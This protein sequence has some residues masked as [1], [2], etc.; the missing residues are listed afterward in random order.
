MTLTEQELQSAVWLKLNEY[1]SSRV[2]ADRA[3]ND[4][5][6]DAIATARLRGR[7]SAWKELL[8]IGQPT[9]VEAQIDG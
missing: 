5:D 8:A 6:L 7:L 3:R 1:I 9:P 4:G 2:E